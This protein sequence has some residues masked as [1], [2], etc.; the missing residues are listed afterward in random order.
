[1]E[2]RISEEWTGG[3]LDNGMEDFRKI[4]WRILGELNRG[5]QENEVEDEMEDFR[6][7][8]WSISGE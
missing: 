2:W 6:R 8:A 3:Y 5:F 7:I 4:T 1:M